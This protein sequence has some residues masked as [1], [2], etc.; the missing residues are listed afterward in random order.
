MDVLRG[1]CSGDR[2]RWWMDRF[3]AGFDMKQAGCRLQI[4]SVKYEGQQDGKGDGARKNG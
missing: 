1:D 2:E 4:S 3:C